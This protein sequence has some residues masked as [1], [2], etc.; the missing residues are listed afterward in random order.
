MGLG[1]D[2]CQ[3]VPWG[4]PGLLFSAPSRHALSHGAH[5]SLHRGWKQGGGVEAF[6]GTGP[7]VLLEPAGQNR[8]WQAL[9]QPVW[10]LAQWLV[11]ARPSAGPDGPAQPSLHPHSLQPCCAMA[12]TWPRVSA[13][14]SRGYD[15]GQ[16]YWRQLGIPRGAQ[17]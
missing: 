7:G 17:I 1:P 9:W 5:S 13:P 14:S 8:A 11:H 16:L 4:P 15:T 12:H 6:V 3:I 10:A 2:H